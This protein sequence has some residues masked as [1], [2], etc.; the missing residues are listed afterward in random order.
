MRGAIGR[1]AEDATSSVHELTLLHVALAHH[2]ADAA[3]AAL[4]AAG[5]APAEVDVVGSHGQT[6][7]HIPGEATI[8]GTPARGT[9]QIGD[10][11]T[12][13]ARLRA[14]VVYDFRAADMAA[15]GQGAP[16]VPYLDYCLFCSD[17]E[18][19][20]LLNLGGIGNLTVIPRSATPEDLIAFDTGPANMVIDAL[21]SRLLGTSYDA[22]GAGAAAG[23]TDE[24][25]VDRLLG[26]PYFV[27]PPPKSTGRER[28]GAAFVDRLI[29]E[30][31]SAPA[32]LLATATALTVRSVAD[33]YRRFAEPRHR[34]D[35]LIVSGGGHRNSTLMAGLRE[36]FAP[37]VVE[38]TAPHGVDPDAKEAVLF[39][40][41]AHEW[42]NG[43]ATSLPAVTGAARPA[44]LGALAVGW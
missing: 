18:T 20:G 34:M 27:A 36:A 6:V 43:V 28:F 11:A 14:P 2:F 25:L 17:A 5:V 8:G 13:A 16:L 29:A 33:A 44:L 35:R 12:I 1:N 9:M 4:A 21:A 15:G 31:P 19:R 30:G 10:A 3:E 26:D 41:L 37:A 24:A 39:A 22:D 23:A 32:D 42:A 38:T 7:Q 40:V